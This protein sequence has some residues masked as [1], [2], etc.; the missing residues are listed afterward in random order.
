MRRVALIVLLSIAAR[1]GDDK[2]KTRFAPG[3]AESYPNHQTADKITIAAVP[4][5]SEEQARSA[6]SE[7]DR[8]Q[9][10][11]IAQGWMSMLR[12][13]P[14]F[15]EQ[16]FDAESKAKGAGQDDSESSH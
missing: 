9:W 8:E 1:A 5:V 16:A 3:P 11:R 10:L 12:K 7:L 2:D 13:R 4:Y 14:Q 6:L 15:D